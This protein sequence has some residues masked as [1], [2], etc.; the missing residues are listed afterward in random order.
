LLWHLGSGK[1]FNMND[2]IDY[3][4]EVVKAHLDGPVDQSR[5]RLSLRDIVGVFLGALLGFATV[6]GW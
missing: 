2:L 6:G 4:V 5:F 3:Q 1:L